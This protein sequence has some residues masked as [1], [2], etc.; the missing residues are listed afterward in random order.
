MNDLPA[1]DPKLESRALHERL[2]STFVKSE[3]IVF[4]T[5]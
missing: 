5:I 4:D 3:L 1:L 2:K